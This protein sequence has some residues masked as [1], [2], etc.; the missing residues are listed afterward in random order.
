MGELE[1]IAAIERVLERR[2]ERVVRWMGDDAAV[3]RARPYAVTTI[4]TVADGV[5]F[6]LATHSPA[7]VGWKAMAQSLSDLAAMGAEAGEAYVSLA[8]P[9]EFGAEPALELVRG[10][11]ELAGVSGVTIAGGDVIASP[12]LVVSVAATGWADTE[13]RARGPRRRPARRPASA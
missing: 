6:E 5:H 12:T 11:E 9:E 8:L 13:E 4:D 1:L 3:V 7:D 10:M 2:G